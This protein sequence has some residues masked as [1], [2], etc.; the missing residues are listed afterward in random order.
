MRAGIF[1]TIVTTPSFAQYL[2]NRL[3]QTGEKITSLRHIV[4]GGGPGGGIPA[5]SGHIEAG[6]GAFVNE[7]LGICDLAPSLFRECHARQRRHLSGRRHV[8][9]DLVPPAS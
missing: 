6:T 5:I 8:A 4:P 9:P 2:A 3:E 7:V 1:D